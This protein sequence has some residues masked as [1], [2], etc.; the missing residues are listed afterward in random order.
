[1]FG[2]KLK[3]EL[4]VK[5]SALSDLEG[6]L[7][8]IKYNVATIEFTPEGVILDAN[9]LFLDICG[10]NLSE[11]Q[12]K[13]H[14]VMCQTTYTST[15]DYRNFWKNIQKGTS[16]R[17]TFERVNKEGNVL[18]L[19]A[20]YFPVTI[21]GKIQKVMKIAYDVT[22][23]FIENEAK[24]NILQALD[25]SLAIIEFEPN[26]TIIQANDNFLSSVNYRLSDIKGQHHRIFC[27]NDFYHDNPT[28]WND[29]AKGMFKSGQFLRKNSQN[30]HIWLEATY[31]PI[32]DK[33]GKV[34]KVIKFASDITQQ[35][36]QNQ[37]VSK[38]AEI[39]YNTSQET[40]EI[41]Q[42]GSA[43]LNE[44]VDVS[45]KITERVRD[46]SVKIQMLNTQSQSIEEI[47]ST[48]KNIADQTNLLALNAAIEAARAGEQGRGFAVVADEVRLLASRTS[49][50]TTE[51]A[52]V[53]LENKA[54]TED[55][56]AAMNTVAQIS[57]DGM[58]KITEVSAV[59]DRIHNGANNISRTVLAL[60]ER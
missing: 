23:K 19:E 46:T 1:M 47:V 10:Y 5:N 14:S 12:G 38:A 49:L 15:E 32:L 42:Q 35:I 22:D 2:R 25:R 43:F 33:N 24:D 56:T 41:A 28:F 4:S 53:V 11:V 57:Q 3:K 18:W 9:P 39:A 48:I 27:D 54:L 45:I 44:S 30:E 21:N 55:V 7:A 58:E 8:S 16:Q 31:N 40:A 51:I 59:M 37:A 17:G 36:E 60:S 52:N 13:H 26:G 20:T 34:T 29:L 50:S 6:I